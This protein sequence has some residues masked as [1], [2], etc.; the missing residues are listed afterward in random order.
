MLEHG[1]SPIQKQNSKIVQVFQNFFTK[2]L[3]IIIQSRAVLDSLTSGNDIVPTSKINKWFNLHMSNPT[4][5]WLRSELRS[6]KAHAD[7]A[8]LPPMIIE[9]YLDLRHLNA[10]ELVML[11]NEKGKLCTVAEGNSKKQEVVIERWLI[12]FDQAELVEIGADELPFI[13]KQAI[14]LLRV[15]YTISRALPAFRLKKLVSKPCNKHLSLGNR[16]IDVE[17]PISS[18]GRIGLS[19]PILPAQFRQGSHMTQKSFTPIKTSSG[20]LRVSVAYRNH[21]NFKVIDHEERLSDQFLITDKATADETLSSL[22][23]G[24]EENSGRASSSGIFGVG[25]SVE[26]EH[27]INLPEAKDIHHAKFSFLPCSSYQNEMDR[28]HA[29]TKTVNIAASISG[30]GTKHSIQPFKVGSISNSPPPQSIL[31]TPTSY[32]SGSVERRIS[33]TSNRNGSN[34]SLAALLRNQR[35][36]VSL[37]NT[38]LAVAGTTSQSHPNTILFPR[39]ISSSH[40]SHNQ[41]DEH[42]GENVASTPRFSSSFGSR[43][44][45]RFSSTSG[46]NNEISSSLLGTSVELGAPSA[47]ISGLYIDDDISTFVRMIDGKSDLRLTH[48]TSDPKA[49]PSND[50]NS[51]I[52]ALNRFQ[53]LKSQHQQLGDSVS[54]SLVLQRDRSGS[55][56]SQSINASASPSRKQSRSGSLQPSILPGSNLPS[57][58]SRLQTSGVDSAI[59]SASPRSMMG[60]KGS[61]TSP[62]LAYFKTATNKLVAS[63]LTATTIAHATHLPGISKKEGISGLATSPSIYSGVKLPNGYDDSFNDHSTDFYSLGLRSKAPQMPMHEAEMGYDIDDLLFEM[64][65]TK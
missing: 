35:G 38:P 46:K 10:R 56:G 4:D 45:R 3:Q 43:Q 53:L 18:K 40:G 29:K 33:I 24:E 48:S 37:S 57:I 42:Y 21:Y 28:N 27:R 49:G 61:F 30:S 6:W 13:Y 32:P 36:S 7:T 1:T 64:T 9:T 15:I 34:A 5:E 60:L 65:D 16:F 26:G 59:G 31:G 44:S 63:P 50:S 52:D 39:S 25:N 17:Q 14:V 22:M 20:S 62:N 58:T 19:K 41:A 51:H 11:E 47:L 54:A 55:R 2:A 8:I 12:E 23:H